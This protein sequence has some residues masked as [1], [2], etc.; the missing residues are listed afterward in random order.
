MIARAA[1]TRLPRRKRPIKPD[2][3][4]ICELAF[5]RTTYIYIY[6]YIYPPLR[7]PRTNI[8]AHN[9]I[10]YIYSRRPETS[11]QGVVLC[12]PPCDA[13]TAAVA[14]PVANDVCSVCVCVLDRQNAVRIDFM[15]A[16][17]FAA[18]R[19]CETNE[20][21]LYIY[22]QLVYNILSRAGLQ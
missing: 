9:T 7:G 21:T 19:L 18:R 16:V 5:I 20:C 14:V 2:C 10:I 22:I 1:K 4:P 3:S 17:A 12:R 13:V 11:P 8:I 6:I 15:A